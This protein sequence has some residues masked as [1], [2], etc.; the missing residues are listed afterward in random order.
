VK[1]L[2][3]VAAFVLSLAIVQTCQAQYYGD[4]LGAIVQANVMQD[5]MAYQQIGAI[6]QQFY[7]ARQNERMQTGYMGYIPGPVSQADLFN[8]INE[9]KGAFQSYNDQ[10]HYLSARQSA[11]IERWSEAF[12]GEW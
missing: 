9:M 6:T 2:Q 7:D 1:T 8:S 5:S 12:R 10:Y 11:A 4:G 3:I